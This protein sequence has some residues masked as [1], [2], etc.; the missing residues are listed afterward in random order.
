MFRILVVEDDRI[1]NRVMCATLRSHGYTPVAAYDG[2]EA[3]GLLEREKFD[4]MIADVMMPKLDGYELTNTL[5]AEGSTLP[6]L[7][8]TAR[9]RR[10]T[11]T[12]A[13]WWAP[14]TT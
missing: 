6:I 13:S 5:R 8:V 4:L 2:E 10:R 12:G 11:S 7:M 9:D 3:L 1:A 14:M